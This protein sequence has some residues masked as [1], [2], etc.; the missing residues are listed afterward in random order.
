[1]R[2]EFNK[3]TQLVAWNRAQGRCEKCTAKLFP[4]NIEYHHDKECTFGGGAEATNCIVLCR[5]CH[6]LITNVRAAVIAKS[7]RQRAGNVGIRKPRTIRAWR[8]FDGTPVYAE[9]ER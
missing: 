9:R 3:A 5:A 1:M 8:R 7:N 4:G 6:R 2:A